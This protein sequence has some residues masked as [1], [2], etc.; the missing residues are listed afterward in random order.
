MVHVWSLESQIL[1][2][3]W[4]IVGRE[5]AVAECVVCTLLCGVISVSHVISHLAGRASG[6]WIINTKD[7]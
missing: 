4:Y 2:T 1:A 7:Q 3:G 5:S 6:I